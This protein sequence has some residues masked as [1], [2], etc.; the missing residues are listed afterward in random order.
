MKDKA[1]AFDFDG[2]LVHSG[3]DKCVHIMYA[4]WSKHSSPAVRSLPPRLPT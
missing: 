3:S 4:A 1:I 2:T